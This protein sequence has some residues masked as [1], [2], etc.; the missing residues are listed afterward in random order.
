MN[1]FESI[2]E[3]AGIPLEDVARRFEQL[4]S[5]VQE[6]LAFR[7]GFDSGKA[8]TLEE[9]ADAFNISRERVRQIEQKAFAKMRHQNP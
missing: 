4:D 6:I 7:H 1:G 2:A 3:S 5:Q 9:C 8:R